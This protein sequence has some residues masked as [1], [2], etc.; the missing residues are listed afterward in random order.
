[1]FQDV[2]VPLA[3]GSPEPDP[4][5]PTG[6]KQ[7][8]RLPSLDLLAKLLLV[9]PR[10]P[11]TFSAARARCRLVVT[12]VSTRTQSHLSPVAAFLPLSTTFS[13][14]LHLQLPKCLSAACK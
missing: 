13:S 9:Q 14:Q 6:A 8:G 2:R 4:A 7:R 3:L 10:T 1:M 12:R 11:L 5:L